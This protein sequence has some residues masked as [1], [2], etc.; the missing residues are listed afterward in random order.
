MFNRSV[1]W[2]SPSFSILPFPRNRQASLGGA[3]DQ[4]CWLVPQILLQLLVLSRGIIP[5]RTGAEE[6]GSDCLTCLLLFQWDSF[7]SG[8]KL[9]SA[10]SPLSRSQNPCASR[11]ASRNYQLPWVYVSGKYACVGH[12][13]QDTKQ[14]L[15]TW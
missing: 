12:V 8:F 9:N 7:T 11:G 15:I 13:D 14:S 4:E 1:F 10:G 6:D 5:Q 2:L 3:G